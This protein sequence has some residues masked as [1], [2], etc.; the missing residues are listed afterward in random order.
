MDRVRIGIIGV[1]NIATLNVP[2]Y[3]AHESCDVIAIC[4]P[5]AG[6][7]EKRAR[8]WGIDRTYT[9]LAGL[10][11]DDDIDAVEILGP[12]PLHAEHVRPDSGQGA[13]G[14]GARFGVVGGQPGPG[15]GRR[16]RPPV[17]LVL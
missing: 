15:G 14:L 7:L 13:F 9:D 6:V 2:G 12:T 1:G 4:D 8:E 3:L 10:L 17:A 11:A 5:R 16:K